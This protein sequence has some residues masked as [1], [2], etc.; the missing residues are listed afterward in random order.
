MRCE[1]ACLG[2]IL[3]GFAGILPR[4]DE[5]FHM[6]THKWASPARWDRAFFNQLCFIFYVLHDD[7]TSMFIVKTT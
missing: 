1:P 3:L 4:R 5:N 6:N 7:F 2:E